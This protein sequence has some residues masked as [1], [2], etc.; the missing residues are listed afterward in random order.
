MR[1]VVRRFVP[2]A[3]S[4]FSPDVRT[5]GRVRGHVVRVRPMATVLG[6]RLH[7]VVQPNGFALPFGLRTPDKISEE[8]THY[9]VP[10]GD[11]RTRLMPPSPLPFIAFFDCRYLSASI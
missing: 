1:R 6:R 8:A 9:T 2:R 11:V 3:A 5:V 4:R 7:G 10:G